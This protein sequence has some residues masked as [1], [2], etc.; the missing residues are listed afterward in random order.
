[1]PLA[2]FPAVKRKHLRHFRFWRAV[3]FESVW[4][5]CPNF[6]TNRISRRE[7][8]WMTDISQFKWS[9]PH[10][11]FKDSASFCYCAY[12]LRISGY[13]GCWRN[14]PTNPTIFLRGLRL[15]GKSRSYQGLSESER[16][17]GGSRAIFG[18][19]WAYKIWKDIAIHSL[20]FN[21]FR[22]MVA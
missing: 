18:G 1:M 16:K 17:T 8:L 7:N 15:C 10:L 14:L 6:P 19:H 13:S 22:I 11:S 21:A 5:P 12:V 9:F 20:Y 2:A 3:T 4:K